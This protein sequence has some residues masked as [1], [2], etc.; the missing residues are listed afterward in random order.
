MSK[1][2]EGIIVIEFTFFVAGPSAGKMLADW[3]AQVIKI[4]PLTGEP[5]RSMGKVLGL[6]T[7]AI[8]NPAW[9]M[10]NGGKQVISIN[11][12][13][14]RG[15]EIMDKLLA[16]ANIFISN[17]RLQA[18]QRLGLSY[19]DISRRHPHIIWGHLSGYGTKG[20]DAE[21]PGFD[22]AAFW[23]RSGAL[24]DIA[25]KDGN[26]LTNP[27]GLGDIATGCAL[28]GGVAACL[29]KQARTGK[30]DK[31]TTSLF[32]T[33]IWHSA[34]LIQATWYGDPWP[35]SRKKPFSPLCNSFCCKDG[36]WVYVSIMDYQRYFK[37]LCKVLNREDLITDKRF[38]SED[39]LRIHCAEFTQIM[40]DIFA[41][42]SYD[43]WDALLIKADIVHDKIVHFKDVSNDP[44]A[45]ANHYIT[46]T[47]NK[48]EDIEIIP[49]T[50]VQFNEHI[51]EHRAAPSLGEDTD[52]ILKEIGYTQEAIHQFRQ[53]KIIY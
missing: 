14:Q 23:S 3:G 47:K 13:T 35:K 7:D 20:T 36:K 45:I 38:S 30:G 44:Q 32:G 6:R 18:L 16:R 51:T 4:E 29:H 27:F 9:E 40:D 33:G 11:M 2:L 43:E 8:S 1:P 37:A 12:K 22:A 10:L 26:P 25:D 17:C 24:R 19:E 48:D 31:V 41:T 49:S 39:A 5:G 52:A 28:A 50:P 42:R 53:D 34:C 46:F 21:K 15:Q